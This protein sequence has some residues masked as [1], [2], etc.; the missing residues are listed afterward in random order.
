MLGICV[1]EAFPSDDSDL[2]NDD[3]SM[4]PQEIRTSFD[5]PRAQG[6]Y[7]LGEERDCE[8][9]GPINP[10]LPLGLVSLL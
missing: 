3:I 8:G 6:D 7:A 10:I 1:R 9:K 5:L 2:E 4:C